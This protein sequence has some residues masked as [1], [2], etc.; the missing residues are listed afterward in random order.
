LSRRA[1]VKDV[2]GED[3]NERNEG[4]EAEGSKA[5]VGVLGVAVDPTTRLC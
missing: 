1:D 3:G 5:G 4:V 2:E